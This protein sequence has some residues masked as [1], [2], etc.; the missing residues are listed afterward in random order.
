MKMVLPDPPL[1]TDYE[2]MYLLVVKAILTSQNKKKKMVTLVNS[3][4]KRKH[5]IRIY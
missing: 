1:I 5:I 2:D 3:K 4:I